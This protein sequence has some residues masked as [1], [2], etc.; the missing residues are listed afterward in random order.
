MKRCLLFSLLVLA[1]A[2]G[3]A[4]MVFAQTTEAHMVPFYEDFEGIH[5]QDEVISTW[6]QQSEKKSDAWVFNAETDYN[7]EP[8]NGKWN[9]TLLWGNI[10]WLFT[11]V[12]LE[13]GKPY[14][15]AMY[16]RQDGTY[17]KDAVL[18]VYLCAEADMNARKTMITETMLTN[19]NYEYINKDF[20]VDSTATYVL[21]I[22]GEVGATPMYISLDDISLVEF[23]KYTI[24]VTPTEHCTVVLNTE[25]TYPN[26]AIDV[27]VTM[28]RGY[29]LDSLTANT[30]NVSLNWYEGN[31]ADFTM[32]GEDVVLTPHVRPA[33]SGV[34]DIIDIP[35]HTTVRA[36][37]NGVE[38]A[39]HSTIY[40]GDTLCFEYIPDAGYVLSQYNECTTIQSYFFVDDTCHLTVRHIDADF[41]GTKVRVE[42]P[43]NTT[44]VVKWNDLGCGY[45][46]LV[47]DHKIQNF[48][49][50]KG[51]HHTADTTY[52]VEGLTTGQTYYAYVCARVQGAEEVWNEAQFVMAQKQESGDGCVLTI[53]GYDRYGDGWNG[54]KLHFVENG[55]ETVI[56]M[57]DG[58][59]GTFTYTTRGGKVDI[60]WTKGDYDDEVS[61]R[62]TNADGDILL[63][64]QE[65]DMTNVQDGVLLWNGN[66]CSLCPTPQVV[67][68]ATDGT[69]ITMRWRKTDAAAYNVAL[70]NG[71][72][73]A[74]HFDIV[75]IRTTDT[76]YTFHNI[77]TCLYYAAAVQALC[78]EQS[79]STWIIAGE[80]EPKV[81]AVMS[82]Q[83]ITLDYHA[84]GDYMR[85]IRSD[86]YGYPP[87]NSLFYSLTLSETTTISLAGSIDD[88]RAIFTIRPINDEGNPINSIYWED[89]DT[90]TLQ[91]GKYGISCR[92]RYGD[93]G[94]D[95]DV[96]ICRV[97]PVHYTPITLP[98][99]SD[100]LTNSEWYAGDGKTGFYRGYEFSLTETTRLEIRMETDWED[101]YSTF[102]LFEYADGEDTKICNEARYVDSLQ[103]GTYHLIALTQDTLS[104]YVLSIGTPA[105]YRFEPISTDTI[106]SGTVT[107]DGL[108]PFNNIMVPG[109]GYTFTVDAQQLYGALLYTDRPDSVFA[110][111]YYDPQLTQAMTFFE[112][113]GADSTYYVILADLD[114]IPL[115]A[116]VYNFSQ[117]PEA[118]AGFVYAQHPVCAPDS[119]PV[120]AVLPVGEVRRTAINKHSEVL[121]FDAD[122][123]IYTVGYEAY[124]VHLEAGKMYRFY[125]EDIQG[126]NKGALYLIDPTLKQGD[127]L[128]N[129]IGHEGLDPN[130]ATFTYAASKDMDC[131][132]L[133][134]SQFSRQDDR[135]DYTVAYEE[136]SAFETLLRQARPVTLP[137]RE[138]A[139]FG[140]AKYIWSHTY[141]WY[142][143]VNGNAFTDYGV[144]PAVS[145]TVQ[146]AAGDTLFAMFSADDEAVLHFYHL[147]ADNT[148]VI[149]DSIHGYS[150]IAER[151][152]YYN[153]SDSVETITVIASVDNYRP[154][155]HR[156]DIV[157]S[158]SSQD[159]APKTATAHASESALYVEQYDLMTVRD[160]L[161]RLTLTAL[162][163][164]GQAIATIDNVP[165]Y[166]DID[167]TAGSATYEANQ[168][169]LPT[170]YAF[171][172]GVEYITVAIK[173]V[174]TDTEDTTPQ[175]TAEP[176]ARLILDGGSLYVLTPDGT[177]YTI[178]GQKVR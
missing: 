16:A 47:S 121:Q 51:I 81:P 13:T 98:Y 73:T 44:A 63:D 133:F 166:W 82:W 21:G 68:F 3:V 23:K 97:N 84:K 125:A 4:D 177:R 113:F 156:Y 146:V 43:D 17:T 59:H 178:T 152:Y 37:V 76:V 119:L 154:G 138:Q 57:T 136:V 120:S 110:R 8:H 161:S 100:T 105:T 150:Y 163:E 93:K 118:Q 109:K 19:G 145:Y 101:D 36:T 107:A 134:C 167:L 122:H 131:T 9:A 26:Y 2:A 172:K 61:F 62:I 14:R 153:A 41:I 78:E 94:T 49:F 58:G 86:N 148:P 33:K 52:T 32:P 60:T 140:A 38:T 90:I 175:D 74:E 155:R 132:L 85:D 35:D 12:Q 29:I 149:I 30:T 168:A 31:Y 15:V 126:T 66:P 103:A 46:V 83:P 151:G 137:L 18:Q 157:L 162:D 72:A 65:G 34:L 54:G 71:T 70:Y 77:D 5:T 80:H 169:D 1:G 24:S 28:D 112:S 111:V 42:C 99:L 115:Y 116:V 45:D 173:P 104:Q 75:A 92:H 158:A 11:P 142:A 102:M 135:A 147:Y 67:E 124:S 25:A 10:D 91:A 40:E 114:T 79:A 106:I 129:S 176:K 96:H 89:M 69:D 130:T 159:I 144:Y 50:Q 56:A 123:E 53:D 141:Q 171:A 39:N 7:R 20:T 164:Q 143:D 95:Y 128:Y 160:A 117:S 55:V 6:V 88:H 48:R 174:T 165:F 139:D 27:R 87:Q 64:M 127:F 22:R 108:Y 170:G